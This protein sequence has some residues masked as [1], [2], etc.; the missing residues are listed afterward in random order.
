MQNF[1]FTKTMLINNPEALE[2][3]IGTETLAVTGSARGMTSLVSFTLYELGYFIGHELQMHNFEDL[4][5]QRA[6]PNRKVWSRPLKYRKPLRDLIT[7]R[8]AEHV[9]WGFKI[10]GAVGY[11]PELPPLLR[12]P[13]IVLCI[14]NPVAI[15]RSVM[16]RN[17]Q[18]SGGISTA[19]RNAKKWIPAMDFLMEHETLPSIILDMDG[20]Q[21]Q[22]KVFLREFSAAL[23]LDGDLDDIL[24]QISKRGYK[25]AE[26]REGVRFMRSNGEPAPEIEHPKKLPS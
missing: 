10:P 24:P 6:F 23:K 14:R 20:V 9:R 12:N 5:F 2:R 21:R 3:A 25:R 17:P 13:V 18:V 1:E 11:V 16:T 22:P 8:N 7:A 15:C 4:E 19:Y 26:S